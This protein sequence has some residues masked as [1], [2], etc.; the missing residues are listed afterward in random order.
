MRI[1][2]I[3][4]DKEFSDIR[5]IVVNNKLEVNFDYLLG[6]YLPFQLLITK[7]TAFKGLTIKFNDTFIPEINGNPSFEFNHEFLDNSIKDYMKEQGFDDKSP[8]ANA[9]SG[10]IDSSVTALVLKPSLIYSGYYDDPDCDETKYSKAIAEEINADQKTYLLTE[11]DFLDNVDDCFESFCVPA[12]GMGSIMEYATLKKLLFDY[13]EVKQIVFGNGGDEVFMGY[14][15]NYYVKELVSNSK[16]TPEW[17]PNFLM[18]KK[19]I[20]NNV[21][22]FVIMSAMNRGGLNSLYSEFTKYKFLP[23]INGIK[24]YIS[25]LLYVNIN[26][27]LPTLLHV[28]EQLCR[29]LGATPFNPLTGN[30]FVDNALNINK[31]ITEIP[32]QRLRESCSNI[33]NIVKDNRIKRGFPMPYKD[34]SRVNEMFREY[35]ISFFKRPEVKVSISEYVGMN[36]YTWGVFQAEMFLK[37]YYNKG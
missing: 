20:T 25:K 11:D 31:D 12:G 16:Q 30:L 24:D 2:Y 18:S 29:G 33:P 17:M 3:Y 6:E 34:W 36:R 19:S 13:P 26:I 28:V 8:Y 10:G 35:Y 4:K 7:Q 23:Q 9:V 21:L 1:K 22:D 15:Y 32:K 37:K 14:Y 27:I 5:D